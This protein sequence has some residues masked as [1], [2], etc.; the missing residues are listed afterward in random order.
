MSGTK[1]ASEAKLRSGFRSIE[2]FATPQ[3]G[4]IV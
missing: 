4:E 1:G 2:W 3:A